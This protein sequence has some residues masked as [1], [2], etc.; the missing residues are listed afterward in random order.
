MNLR[1][2]AGELLPGMYV[3][4]V[5]RQSGQMQVTTQGWVR[6]AAAIAALR[7]RGIEEVLIDPSKTIT[8]SEA[9]AVQ[10]AQLAAAAAAASEAATA[11]AG[12]SD[13]VSA[14]VQAAKVPLETE[15][16]RAAKLY[17]EAKALQQKAFDDIKAG[18]PLALEPMQNMATA[19]IDSVF[20]NQDALLCMSRIREKDAYLL[21]HSVNV[22]ILMTVLARQLKLEE[23][24]IHELAT[25]ALLH[26]LGKILVPDHILQK[27]GKLTDEEFVE[28]RRHVEY[29]Y[30]VVKQMPGIA[31]RSLEVLI[32][33]HERL[34]GRGYPHKLQ[35]EQISRY[36]RMIAIVDTYDAITAS[37]VYK[38]GFT[39]THAF[40]I[41]RE[42]AG[43]G[44]DNELVAEFI[45]AIG[46][47]PVGSLVRLK[48]QR[49]GIVI[50]SGS[51]DPLR[52]VVKVFYHSK[53]RQQLPVTDVDLAAARC[54]DEIE[55]A[56][57]PEQ[58][59][60]DLIGFLRSIA[61]V[62]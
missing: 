61:G 9:A 53:F 8:G 3:V 1:L 62:K 26:D 30:E 28:M 51:A 46:V 38:D 32:Q 45:R 7:E 17:A 20:R 41:L 29:G 40:K 10:A 5:V 18:R 50:Q 21:E 44:Y 37:R 48:S 22:S 27:P 55:A 59:K 57:K 35:G 25:G 47:F 56:V 4:E 36:G 31:P 14:V 58:F 24:V 39:S 6:T 19:F 11:K 13:P 54:E 15:L 43:T 49:L 34:D 60:I 33:H 12:Q 23:S 52:P 16:N 42:A 2:K